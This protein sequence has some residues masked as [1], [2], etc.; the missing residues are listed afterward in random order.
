MSRFQKKFHLSVSVVLLCSLVL[1][2]GCDWS[3][4][5]DLMRAEKALKTAD[6]AN[7]EHWA[8][9]EYQKAQ[10]FFVEAMDEARVRNVNNA[11]DLALEARMWAEEATF[12]AIQR[13]EEMQKEKDAISSKKY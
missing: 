11:R 8:T 3:A 12:L 6:K 1:I 10:K 7:A 9:R 4:R 2:S 5:W 13:A